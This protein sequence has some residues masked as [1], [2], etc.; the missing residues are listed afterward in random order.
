MPGVHPG[1]DMRTKLVTLAVGLLAVVCPRA[2]AQS[3]TFG[4]FLGTVTD[5][6]GA[7]V[8]GATVTIVNKET[9]VS[10]T[11]T[12][13]ERGDYLADKLLPGVYELQVALPGFKKEIATDVRLTS[14]QKARVDFLLTA[15]DISDSVTVTGQ[16]VTLDTATADRSST[17][18][19][20]QITSLPLSGR[21]LTVLSELTT[22]AVGVRFSTD[23]RFY[24][25]GGGIPAA[26]GLRPDLSSSIL[27]DGANN[28]DYIDMKPA[29]KA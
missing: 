2:H 7:V 16:S 5:S 25:D 3:V 29:V 18:D 22:G 19:E 11:T 23:T 10:R 8:P 28:Q 14:S 15:G 6:S 20:K 12:T 13:N 17:I 21:S 24:R 1:G 4:Q 26:N 27:Y 9:G